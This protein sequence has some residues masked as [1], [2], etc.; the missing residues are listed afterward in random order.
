MVKTCDKSNKA[1]QP[2]SVRTSIVKSCTMGGSKK[3][4]LVANDTPDERNKVFFT[5]N[6]N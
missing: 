5:Y 4:T 6:T 2:M 3:R 1:N